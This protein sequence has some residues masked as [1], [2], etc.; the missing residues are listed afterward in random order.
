MLDRLFSL[1]IKV[2]KLKNTMLCHGRVGQYQESAKVL[3][4]LHSVKEGK[5]ITSYKSLLCHGRVGQYQESA[6]V[7]DNLHSVKEGI[8]I[9][10]YKSVRM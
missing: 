4:N 1:T 6:K 2:V 3:D 8:M 10:S 9:T 7:L 5:M